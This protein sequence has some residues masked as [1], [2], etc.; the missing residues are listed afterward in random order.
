MAMGVSNVAAIIFTFVAV[1]EIISEKQQSESENKENKSIL[2]RV[3]IYSMLFAVSL[4]G[5]FELVVKYEYCYY[6][7]CIQ[8]V[9][10]PLEKGPGKG[11]ITSARSKV[12]YTS[13]YDEID[14]YKNKTPDSILLLNYKAWGYLYLDDFTCSSYSAWT[15]GLGKPTLPKYVYLPIG[16]A[17]AMGINDVEQ[18]AKDNNYIIA[19]KSS[20]SYKLERAE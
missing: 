17:E 18:L 5:I 3:C 9:S 15:S 19:D 20:V 4:Q 2:K 10:S 12:L 6:D 13:Y 7:G 14:Y 16:I 11:I 1:K 8:Y